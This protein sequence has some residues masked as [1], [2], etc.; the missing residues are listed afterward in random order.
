MS[1]SI[2]KIFNLGFPWTTSDPFLFCVYHQDFYP[3]GKS[4][5]SPAVS[6]KGR[7]IGQDFTLKDG[8]RMYHG[9]NIPG[10]PHHPHRGF[11]TVTVVNKGLVDHSDSL[12]CAGRYGN[13]DV[14]WLTTGNGVQHAEMFPLLN[15]NRDNP[16]E[17]FQIWLNLP[18]NNKMV[19]PSYKMLW[20]EDIPIKTY[21]AGNGATTT[22]KV[23][24]GELHET[25]ALEPTPHSWAND[26]KNNVAIWT[27][28]M[29]ASGKWTIPK[30]LE[31]LNRTIYFFE[32]DQLRVGSEEISVNQGVELLSNSEV[33]IENSGETS[34]RLLLLQGRPIGE[35]VAQ[36]GPFVM[37]TEAEVQQA[38]QDYQQTQFGGWPWD[39]PDPIHGNR[40]RFAQHAD[41]T[42]EVPKS[43]KQ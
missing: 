41:G 13:G 2:I 43:N 42:E 38:F 31:G 27:I 39:R 22:V 16:S 9:E 30:S 24:A 6:L 25:K 40:G 8:W 32:G 7:N 15:Q 26:E 34:A 10:F 18:A 19:T 20:N 29:E 11:E 35:P 28:E 36:Y 14:Q 17:L 12:G 5:F 1:D 37:N 33:T 4:D 23:V 3:N 21:V